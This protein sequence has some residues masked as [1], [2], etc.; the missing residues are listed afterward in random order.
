MTTGF[1]FRLDV[2]SALLVIKRLAGSEDFAIEI[3]SDNWYLF[4]SNVGVALD[5]RDLAPPNADTVQIYGITFKRR[6]N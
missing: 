4:L 5:A 1:P 2:V 6:R 3:P